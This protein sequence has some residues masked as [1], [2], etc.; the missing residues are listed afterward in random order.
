M[1]NYR[2]QK[3]NPLAGYR[4]TEGIEPG[5]VVLIT[6]NED[7]YRYQPQAKWAAERKEM[8]EG[9]GMRCDVMTMFEWD[10]YIG[11]IRNF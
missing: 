1:S 11:Q 4:E 3:P 5:A 8:Y 6:V 7:H 9:Q 2:P 10:E